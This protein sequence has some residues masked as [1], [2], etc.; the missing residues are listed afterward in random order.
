MKVKCVLCDTVHDIEDNSLKAKR[1]RNRR[2]TMY[3]CEE[4]DGRIY[5]RTQKR[6]K[7]GNFHLYDGHKKKKDLI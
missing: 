6:H 1:L 3:L 7:T 2:I 4:C 5:D